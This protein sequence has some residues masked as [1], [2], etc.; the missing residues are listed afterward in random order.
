MR[1]LFGLSISALIG[2]VVTLFTRPESK[3]KQA[4]LVWGTIHDAIRHY[5]GSEG[6]END[7]AEALAMP[8]KA[9]TEAPS[10]GEARLPV[11]KISSPVMNQLRTKVGDP[12][13]LTDTRWWLGGLHSMHVV[14]GGEIESSEE[15]VEIGP[16]T[17]DLVITSHRR[18][19]PLKLERL[20]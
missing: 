1:A 16:E 3:E 19:K 17:Y 5:K 11:V 4:G 20:Y 18:D 2:V 13:Y 10:E 7:S 9:E 12:L 14:V 8:R 6:S 15:V